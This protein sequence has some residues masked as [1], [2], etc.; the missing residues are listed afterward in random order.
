MY[1]VSHLANDLV[2][3]LPTAVRLLVEITE[4]CEE[5]LHCLPEHLV[6]LHQEG[7]DSVIVL[8]TVKQCDLEY[9]VNNRTVQDDRKNLS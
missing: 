8:V 7:K 4:D 5:Q 9:S 2:Q 3:P 1:E 6:V